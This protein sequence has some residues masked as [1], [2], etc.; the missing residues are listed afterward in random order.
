VSVTR[1]LIPYKSDLYQI[2]SEEYRRNKTCPSEN[3][4]A[5]S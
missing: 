3:W 5:E 1:R 4:L 2:R